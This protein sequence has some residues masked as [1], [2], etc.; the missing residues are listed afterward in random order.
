VLRTIAHLCADATP[1]AISRYT[2]LSP[3]VIEKSLLKF[4]TLG[5]VRFADEH[6]LSCSAPTAGTHSATTQSIGARPSIVIS[7]PEVFAEA[8][9]RAQ[10]YFIAQQAIEISKRDIPGRLQWIDDMSRMIEIARKSR[11]ATLPSS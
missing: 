1:A 3:A 6:A 9:A 10:E 11:H 2:G 4:E 7:N 5:L 8:E